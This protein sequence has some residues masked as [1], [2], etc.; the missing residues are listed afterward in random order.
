[1]SRD[2]PRMGD[3]HGGNEAEVNR[4]RP[5]PIGRGHSTGAQPVQVRRRHP[6]LARRL[7]RPPDLVTK[8]ATAARATAR[9]LESNSVS[10]AFFP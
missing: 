6:G 1:M 10:F 7:C 4:S 8:M 3:R 2:F 9:T 5:T